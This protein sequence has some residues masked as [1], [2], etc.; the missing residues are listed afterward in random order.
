MQSQMRGY[1]TLQ[2][3]WLSH[4]HPVIRMARTIGSKMKRPLWPNW[5][6]NQSRFIGLCSSLSIYISSLHH[7]HVFICVAVCCQQ[8]WTPD[9]WT[10]PGM[11]SCAFTLA[12][13]FASNL[14]KIESWTRRPEEAGLHPVSGLSFD[15]AFKSVEW[16]PCTCSV[17]FRPTTDAFWEAEAAN[18]MNFYI[19]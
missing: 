3:D 7:E 2:Y 19:I 18:R 6:L 12:L 9:E 17:A 4:P 11:F 14:L 5:R 8:H 15:T 1:S 13:L 10:S 16:N